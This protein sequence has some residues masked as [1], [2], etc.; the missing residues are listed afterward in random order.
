M[1]LAIAVYLVVVNIA[2]L[3]DGASVKMPMWSAILALLASA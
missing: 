3:G 2:I 1:V